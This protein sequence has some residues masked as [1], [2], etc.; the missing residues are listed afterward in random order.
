MTVGKEVWS[1]VRDAFITSANWLCVHGLCLASRD[2]HFDIPVK[3]WTLHNGIIFHT[4]R[5]CFTNLNMCIFFVIISWFLWVH[6]YQRWWIKHGTFP[7]AQWV[8]KVT[9]LKI[10]LPA[11][12]QFLSTEWS[13]VRNTRMKENSISNIKEL[14]DRV[15][16]NQKYKITSVLV[17]FWEKHLL[18][19]SDNALRRWVVWTS[20]KWSYLYIC[21]FLFAYTQYMSSHNISS[22]IL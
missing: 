10:S 4:K 5:T 9:K 11:H 20:N 1:L 2:L 16:E 14:Q 13:E 22:F 17:R 12:R 18:T 21:R 7:K 15:I 6:F 19:E 3:E 8:W